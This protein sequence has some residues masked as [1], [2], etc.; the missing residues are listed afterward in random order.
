MMVTSGTVGKSYGST[1]SV[2]GSAAKQEEVELIEKKK[3]CSCFARNRQ[4]RPSVCAGF[5]VPI[6]EEFCSTRAMLEVWLRGI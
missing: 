5:R 2:G 4:N 3:D 6:P 1:S